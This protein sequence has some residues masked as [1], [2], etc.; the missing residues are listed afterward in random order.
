[1][2]FELC[3]VVTEMDKIVHIML[4]MTKVY[5]TKGGKALLLAFFYFYKDGLIF[6]QR[7]FTLSLMVTSIELCVYI[8]LV[9]TLYVCYVI[10]RDMCMHAT[11]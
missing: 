5:L 10:Q 4:L 1:M 3:R 7:S 2:N 9:L 8:Y 11:V 6:Q